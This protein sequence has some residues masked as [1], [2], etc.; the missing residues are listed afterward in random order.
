VQQT[1]REFCSTKDDMSYYEYAACLQYTKL[2]SNKLDHR[3]GLDIFRREAVD[4]LG[5]TMLQSADDFGGTVDWKQFKKVLDHIQTH[6]GSI[7]LVQSI[8]LSRDVYFN[9]EVEIAPRNIMYYEEIVDEAIRYGDCLRTIFRHYSDINATRKNE[10]DELKEKEAMSGMQMYRFLL[11]SGFIGRHMVVV[12]MEFLDI[13]KDLLAKPTSQ[14]VAY[15]E[16]VVQDPH[17]SANVSHEIKYDFPA[18][19]EL[20]VA[21]ALLSPPSVFS[22]PIE[23]RVERLKS[24]F[25]AVGLPRLAEGEDG[26]SIIDPD[27]LPSWVGSSQQM[28]AVAE[29]ASAMS[30]LLKLEAALPP[31][32]PPPRLQLTNPP[33]GAELAPPPL[34]FEEKL[35]LRAEGKKKGKKKA[36]GPMDDEDTRQHK[37]GEIVYHAH[38]P[39]KKSEKSEDEIREEELQKMLQKNQGAKPRFPPEA[40]FVLIDEPL[41]PPLC[42]DVDITTMMETA[43]AHRRSKDYHMS[44]ELLLHAHAEWFY[45]EFETVLPGFKKHPEPQS[46]Y[47]VDAGNIGVREFVGVPQAGHLERLEDDRDALAVLRTMSD[48]LPAP[49]RLFF[50]LEI[51]SLEVAAGDVDAAIPLLEKATSISEELPTGHVDRALVYCALGRVLA[52]KEDFP[53]AARCYLHAKAI[54]E[55]ATGPESV[56]AATAYHNLAVTYLHM[57]RNEEAIAFLRYAEGLF[58]VFLGETHPRTITASRNLSTSK[59]LALKLGTNVEKPHLFYVPFQNLFAKAKKKGAK[60]KGKK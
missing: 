4:G 41:V 32:P 50:Y 56:D 11:D 6:T 35:A 49:V 52:R 38:R 17:L 59:K 42:S 9:P 12:P 46:S 28:H 16:A 57:G 1:F 18:F 13:A 58:Q 3:I 24:V 60:K 27:L 25:D 20:L 43:S 5:T 34:T 51:A 30:P 39:E 37:W 29:A 26:S 48:A 7:D 33:P 8:R 22:D 45:V 40:A 55:E 14:K 21:V 47:A 36:A 19:M 15:L 23:E 53:F 10:T 31:L 44:K 54:R 2:Y